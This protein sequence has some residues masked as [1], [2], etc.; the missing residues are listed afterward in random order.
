MISGCKAHEDTLASLE[1]T[2]REAID[3]MKNKE[4]PKVI[5]VFF[6]AAKRT[7]LINYDLPSLVTS[8][9]HAVC[10]NS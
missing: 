2:E 3:A 6:A 4:F 1:K 7:L 9:H 8:V 10:Y 5:R